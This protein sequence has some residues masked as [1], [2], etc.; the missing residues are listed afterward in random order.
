[1][2]AKSVVIALPINP[3]LMTTASGSLE[4]VGAT[5]AY[6]FAIPVSNPS[7]LQGTL[8]LQQVDGTTSLGKAKH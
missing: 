6:P 2:V 1:V 8:A 7:P 5:S 3:P 4:A